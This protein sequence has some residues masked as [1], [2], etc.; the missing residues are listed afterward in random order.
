MARIVLGITGSVA[1]YKGAELARSLVR[2][3]H[4][5][6]A[7]L[8][9]GGSRFVT[10]LQ[11]QALTGN[12]VPESQWEPLARD[13]MDHIQ[14]ARWGDVLL[15]APASAD[16]LARTAHGIADDLLSTVTLA[17]TG[18]LIVAPAMNTRMLLNPAT[19]TNL[20]TLVSR[21]IVVVESEEGDLACGE[22][23]AGKMADVER[24]VERVEDL[25]RADL[26]FS[27]IRALVTA[28]PTIEALDPVRII[29]NRSSGRMGFAVAAALRDR[30][31]MVRLVSG[32]TPLEPPADLTE[33][34][35]VRSTAEMSEAVSE[36]FDSCDLLVMAAAPADWRPA[37]SAAGKSPRTEGPIQIRLDPTPDIL[38]GLKDSKGERVVVGFALE[39]GDAAERGRM[40]LER[41]GLD[42]IAVNDPTEDGAG[43]ESL[44][45]HLIL[46]HADGRVEELPAAPKERIA[47]ELLDRVLPYLRRDRV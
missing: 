15:V 14:L 27:G 5:V 44:T 22:Q 18:R 42:L 1:A 37:E 31:A 41:K 23:G 35:R 26:D 17:F 33:V 29:T 24:I 40:K 2:R 3:G 28:G 20:A 4:D 12:P 30:G 19:Q 45:N 9:S 38:G 7:L 21:G 32:P 16:Y 11:L 46:V 10:P 8:S 39:T 47:H 25:L 43:P 6:R 34:V 36:R 13:A